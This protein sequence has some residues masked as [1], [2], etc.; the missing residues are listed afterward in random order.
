VSVRGDNGGVPR[1][2]SRSLTVPAEAID[3]LGHVNNLEYVRW[4]QDVATEHSAAQGWPL[5]RYVALGAGWFV[6]RH[7]VD[8]LRPAFAGDALTLLTWVAAFERS[9]SP[10]RYLFFRPADGQVVARAETLWVFVRYA[11]GAPLRIPPDLQ[12][13]FDVVPDAE[14]LRAVSATPVAG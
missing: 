8:Y 2:Y 7:T 11:T 4:M 1:I 3:V 14:A 9:S 13:A 10:R 5:E 6:R 12:S